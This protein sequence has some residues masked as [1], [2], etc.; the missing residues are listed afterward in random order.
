MAERKWSELASYIT[1][2]SKEICADNGCTE[3]KHECESYAYVTEDGRLIDICSPDFFQGAASRY[4][5][6]SLPWSGTG[7]ELEKGVAEMIAEYYE[8]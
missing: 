2:R 4:V 8:V 6:I 3:E 7:D 5:D 1:R